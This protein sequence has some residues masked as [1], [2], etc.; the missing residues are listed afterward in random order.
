M[1]IILAAT[2][3]SRSSTPAHALCSVQVQGVRRGPDEPEPTPRLLCVVAMFGQ[4][5]SE[6]RAV[7]CS[8]VCRPCPWRRFVMRVGQVEPMTND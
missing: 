4:G 8:E 2:D 6:R 3:S 7:R 5:G 1:R